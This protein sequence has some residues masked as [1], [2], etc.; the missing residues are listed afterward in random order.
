M[1]PIQISVASLIAWIN[2]GSQDNVRPNQDLTFSVFGS[3]QHGKADQVR[4]GAATNGSSNR[5]TPTASS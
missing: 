5:R 3:G 4:K 2:I 1:G